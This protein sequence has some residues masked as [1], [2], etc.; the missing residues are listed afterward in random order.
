MRMIQRQMIWSVLFS[1]ILFALFTGSYL[2][3]FPVDDWT[4]LLETR[5]F[6]LPILFFVPGVAVALGIS[7]GLVSSATYKKQVEEIEFAL[8]HLEQ[9]R[10]IEE[11]SSPPSEELE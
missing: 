4:L 5:I 11:R 6:D 7:F 3:I 10:L 8:G 1:L 2:T 9:G